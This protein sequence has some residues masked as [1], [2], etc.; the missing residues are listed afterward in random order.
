MRGHSFLRYLYHYTSHLPPPALT[1]Y[2][3]TISFW[4]KFLR[5]SRIHTQSGPLHR[6]LQVFGWRGPVEPRGFLGSTD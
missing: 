1:I 4:T 6:N 5:T 3:L 2:D